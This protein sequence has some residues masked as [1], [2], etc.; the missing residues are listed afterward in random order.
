[1]LTLRNKENILI[2][3]DTKSEQKFVHFLKVSSSSDVD[4][5]IFDDPDNCPCAD[6]KYT[7]GKEKLSSSFEDLGTLV[8]EQQKN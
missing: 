1:M 2:P 5:C 4:Y 6:H 7:R 3:R 8:A